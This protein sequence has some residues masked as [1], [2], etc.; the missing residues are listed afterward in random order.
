MYYYLYLLTCGLTQNLDNEIY[1]LIKKI[2]SKE[3]TKI[4]IVTTNLGGILSLFSIALI[5]TII[6]FLFKKRKLGIAVELNLIIST[7]VYI[8]LKNIFQRPR[9]DVIENL[10]DVTGYSF[11]SGHSTNNMAFY[12]FAI[13]LV[14]EN[15]KNKKLKI[16]FCVFLGMIPILIGFSRIYLRVHYFSD[17]IV[18]FCL[19]I[20][21]VVLFI[22]YVYK[23]I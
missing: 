15:V 23:R 7:C 6:L 20:I 4:L 11:P 13:Y 18:G 3:L 21:N 10:I 17:V 12:A 1:N 8:L 5:T 22:N 19:G 9:P 2:Q 14:C 16:I